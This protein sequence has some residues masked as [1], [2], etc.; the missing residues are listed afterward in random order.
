[1]EKTENVNQT[2]RDKNQKLTSANETLNTTNQTLQRKILA[3]ED[4]L[5]KNSPHHL[6][7]SEI[8]N[9]LT[10]NNL[11]ELAM[12]SNFS[13]LISN[14]N[15]KPTAIST[16]PIKGNSITLFRVSKVLLRAKFSLK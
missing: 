13:N 1:M 4:Q 7:P 8:P 6:Q 9:S 10:P 11:V 15:S 3:M 2:L 14:P 16:P 12:N 5:K